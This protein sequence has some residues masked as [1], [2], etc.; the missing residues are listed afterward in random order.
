V[1][2]PFFV[3]LLKKLDDLG[4]GSITRLKVQIVS[5]VGKV[6]MSNVG[7]SLLGLPCDSSLGREVAGLLEPSGHEER[8]FGCS[9]PQTHDVDGS[10][11]PRLPWKVAI[12]Q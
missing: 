3:W 12:R 10:T 9:R 11:E 5:T 8:W 4:S 6:G 2:G 1:S 7:Y